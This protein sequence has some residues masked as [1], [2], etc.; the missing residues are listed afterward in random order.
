MTLEDFKTL[1][2]GIESGA[3]SLAL[4]FGG[5][6]AWYKFWELMEKREAKLRQKKTQMEIHRL[7]KEQEAEERNVGAA[8]EISIRASQESLPNDP[9]RCVSAIVEIENKG[10]AHSRLDYGDNRAPFFVYP[11]NFRDDGTLDFEDGIHYSVPLGRSPKVASPSL[12]VR[13][14]GLERIPFFFRVNSPGLYLLVFSARLTAAEQDIAKDL[15]FKYPGNWVAKQY[16]V[17]K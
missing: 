7:E 16:F 6:W 12:I 13:A 3:V 14:G 8:L 4:L 9:S 15:G 5:V 2:N 11:V 17:V 1:M 10:K